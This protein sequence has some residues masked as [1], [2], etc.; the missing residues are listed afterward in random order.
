MWDRVIDD[1]LDSPPNCSE[2][3]WFGMKVYGDQILGIDC[4]WQ[5]VEEPPK[6]ETKKVGVRFAPEPEMEE[7]QTK[8][9]V[10]ILHKK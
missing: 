5:V 8:T 6:E 9:E 3:Y 7:I 1:C 2:E 10:G 4:F